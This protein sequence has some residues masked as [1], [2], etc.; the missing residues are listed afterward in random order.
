M[1]GAAHVCFGLLGY[2]PN[3]TTCEYIY[4]FYAAHVELL[5][6][7][8]FDGEIPFLE[9][10]VLVQAEVSHKAVKQSKFK[11]GSTRSNQSVH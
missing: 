6:D 3:N 1:Y 8:F 4:I 7:F 11:Q 5:S 2:V 9:A 10:M